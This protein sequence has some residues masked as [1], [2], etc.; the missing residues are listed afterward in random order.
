MRSPTNG[1]QGGGAC[2]PSG[3]D[4]PTHALRLN[5]LLSRLWRASASQSNDSVLCQN[6]NLDSPHHLG[7]TPTTNTQCARQPGL[8][9][10]SFKD[11]EA[12]DIDLSQSTPSF[13][14]SESVPRHLKTREKFKRPSR[15]IARWLPVFIYILNDICNGAFTNIPSVMLYSGWIGGLLLL[16][17]MG[18]LNYYC[19]HLL[20]RMQRVFPGA[21]TMGDM[22]FY[23]TRSGLAMSVTFFLAYGLMFLTSGQ[24][25]S[26]AGTMF[27]TAFSGCFDVTLYKPTWMCVMAA[28]L[29]P[30]SQVRTIKN[31]FPVNLVNVVFLL[32]FCGIGFATRI[33]LAADGPGA[34]L[35]PNPAVPSKLFPTA[36]NVAVAVGP[37]VM[38]DGGQLPPMLGD[39]KMC[40]AEMPVGGIAIVSQMLYY[41]MVILEVIAEMEKPKDFP[42]ANATATAVVMILYT[43]T[44]VL[45]WSVF[46]GSVSNLCSFRGGAVAFVFPFQDT[47]FGRLAFGLLGAGLMGSTLVRIVIITRALHLLVSIHA[48]V[49]ACVRFSSFSHA[50]A[51]TLTHALQG[52]PCQRQQG[53]VEATRRVVRHQHGGRRGRC[54]S[55]ARNPG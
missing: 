51:D 16:W 5:P 26:M 50:F 53:R 40:P 18:A 38:G 31:I 39:T 34:W 24:Q 55:R 23:I 15:G 36:D 45:V 35:G 42:K 41:Q 48:C 29:I 6:R 47:W 10:G 49:H 9:H 8:F 52:A 7:N 44:A 43:V 22:S 4:R 13:S 21:V 25:L 2:E 3:S 32:G 54:S 14:C 46:N 20:Y 28:G 1:D 37:P 12:Y 30:L 11:G 17:S 33:Y 27:Q 19:C